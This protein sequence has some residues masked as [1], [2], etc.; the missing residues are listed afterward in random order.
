MMSQELNPMSSGSPRPRRGRLGCL[1]WLVVIIIIG[2]F[3]GKYLVIPFFITGGGNADTRPV[4]GDPRNFD[5]VAA[6]PGVTDYAGKNSHLV[7]IRAYYVRSD[8]TLDL[9]ASNYNPYVEYKFYRELDAPPPDAPP[10]GAG[11]TVNGKWYEPVDIT[12]YQPGQWRSVSGTVSYTYQNQGMERET[13]SPTA[14][15]YDTFASTPECS[16]KDLWDVALKHDAPK[17]AVAIIEYDANGYSFDISG[18]SVNLDFD[19]ACKLKE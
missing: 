9:N 18:A 13:S 10:V 11:G 3:A 7:S 17:D 2:Y 4:P 14:N 19:L 12:A 5:P 1:L 6:L 8:G 16:F 15:L